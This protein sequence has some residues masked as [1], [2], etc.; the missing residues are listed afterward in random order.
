MEEKEAK[1][2]EGEEKYLILSKE[3]I[4]MLKK[5]LDLKNVVISQK[6]NEILAL[7]TKI[8]LLLDKITEIEQGANTKNISSIRN[9]GVINNQQQST[10]TTKALNVE[11][12][13]EGL[14][15]KFKSLTDR[16]FSV[17]LAIYQLEE[18]LGRV[19][20]SDIANKLNISEIT[21]RCYVNSILNKNIPV[22]RK[23]HFNKKSYLTIN[24]QFRSLNLVGLI[25]RI[26]EGNEQQ[27]VILDPIT[28]I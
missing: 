20:Y 19:T 21:I 22:E 28:T 16:E 8:S 17:F 1:M 3:V 6:N 13:K 7:N 11:G 24:S 4:L 14:E 27:S 18:E 2:E 9:R 15:L 12:F 5:E 25:L 10:I 23:R 26:R